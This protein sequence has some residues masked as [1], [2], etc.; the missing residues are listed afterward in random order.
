MTEQ[1]LGAVTTGGIPA[2]RAARLWVEFLVFYLGVPLVLALRLP[3]Q[4]VW[5]VLGGT[6]LVGIALLHR[7]P[8]FAWSELLRGLRRIDGRMVGAMALGTALVAGV[9]VWWLV[10]GQA[11]Y[12]PRHAPRLWLTI[13]LLYPILSALPQELLFRPLFFRRYGGLMPGQKAAIVANSALFALAHLM[14]WNWPAVIMTF[15]GG[16]IFSEAY[17]R[18]G[19]PLAVLLHAV[20]GAIV[21]TSGLGTFFYHG[22]VPLR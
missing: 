15:L 10:P 7:T 16:L 3:P 5:Y 20:A 4:A 11:L 9:L 21:F 1:R 18:R 22:A 19:F 12:L 8:G 14:F 2:L 17:L 6:T 13:M